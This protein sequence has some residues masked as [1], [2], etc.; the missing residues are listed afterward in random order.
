MTITLP[1]AVLL[2]WASLIISLVIDTSYAAASAAIP[3]DTLLTSH[4]ITISIDI[5]RLTLTGQDII[6]F[7]AKE[8]PA[9][10]RLVI[11]SGSS[12]DAVS[13]DG[14]PL[15]FA[16]K[17]NT[18]KGLTEAVIKLPAIKSNSQDAPMAIK[19]GF[20]GQFSPISSARDKIKRGVAFVSDG[21]IGDEGVFLPSD[22]AWLPRLEDGMAVYE[23]VVSIPEAYSTVME[24][25]LIKTVTTSGIKTEQWRTEYPAEGLSLVAGKYTVDKETYKDIDL[26]TF[27]FNKDNALSRL[28]IDK[29]KGYL[30]MYEGLI[31]PYPFKK[32][33]VVE[34]FLPTGYGMASFTLL[35]S[36]VIRLPFIPDTSLGHEIAHNWWGNSVYQPNDSGNWTEALTTFTA[37]YLYAVKKGEG[38]EFRF[39]KLL[40]YKNFAEAAPLTLAEFNDAT[41]PVSRAVGYNKGAM[42]FVMLQ[43]EI[44]DE[45]F[46]AGLKTFYTKFAFKR[47]HWADLQASFEAASGRKLGWFF[48]QWLSKPGGP[49]ISF[50]GPVLK[51]RFGQKYL[52][53]FTLRQANPALMTLP[54]SFETKDGVVRLS[55]R[56]TKE[57]ETFSI[58]MPAL[59]IAFE[60]DPD[61]EVFRIL[62]DAEVP[63]SLSSCFGDKDAVIIL[64]SQKEAA[65]KYRPVAGLISKDYGASIAADDMP[66]AYTEKTIFV[67]GNEM[68]NMAYKNVKAN[69]P[70]DVSIDDKTLT[71][72]KDRYEL[73]GNL[74][75]IALKDISGKRRAICAFFGN[76]P[77]DK[78]FETGKRLRYF[79]EYSY[80]IFTGAASPVKGRFSGTKV[81]RHEF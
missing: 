14:K 16:V 74:F 54:V 22:S 4:Q 18:S 12:I 66:D 30:A 57:L 60:I 64:P 72:G 20:H 35:G 34:S 68:E 27:F 51:W 67:L 39:L 1:R 80:L 5:S 32:F 58:E 55:L 81:L 19:V 53:Q 13:E 40:G 43:N 59:P 42:L 71:L 10:L 23:S 44:G 52:I 11:R 25:A 2:A 31:G 24:G 17:K 73:A 7:N 47:A 79:G 26:Y 15:R 9:S 75:A 45:A 50:E 21:V 69:L 65:D 3:I 38:R 62:S 8:R 33:A 61:Y 6:T 37:D 48:D 28:Y 77:K 29:T 46:L 56:V 70:K 63:A 36:A 76:G 49:A 78:V 41:E